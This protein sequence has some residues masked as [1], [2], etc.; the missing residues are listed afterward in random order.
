MQL[1]LTF[2]ASPAPCMHKHPQHLDPALAAR[3]G[4]TTGNNLV[5]Q[6][7]AHPPLPPMAHRAQK[8]VG[9]KIFKTSKGVYTAVTPDDLL[10]KGTYGVVYRVRNEK[11]PKDMK[12]VKTFTPETMDE[13]EGIPPTTLRE[14]NALK[15]LK[16]PNILKAEEIVLPQPQQALTDMFVVMELCR[17][18][19]KDKVCDM[20][21]RWLNSDPKY[22]DFARGKCPP[23]L[24]L[25]TTYVREAKLLS[26][27]L[28]NALAYVHSRGIMHRDLKPV[29]IMWGFDDL[30]KF[31]DF[32]LARFLRGNQNSKD[33]VMPQTG[34]VQTMWYRAPEVLLGDE[35]YGAQVDDWSIGCVIAEL[36]RFRRSSS[37]NR[38]ETEPLFNG[39]SDPETLLMIF[40][41]LGRPSVDKEPGKMYLAS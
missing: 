37:S 21:Q 6:P 11:D 7:S 18:T 24:R 40:E 26:Y 14:I 15:V 22:Y 9:K 2:V 29:N 19:L 38:V 35:T 27:Q 25:P 30:L 17:G 5:P 1:V 23:S 4:K 31:G 33:C 28:L 20:I 39:R 36:F 41:T 34:E 13:N 10:G 32:G 12:A 3:F 16:H 8:E